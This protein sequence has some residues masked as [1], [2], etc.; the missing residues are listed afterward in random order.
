[1]A[2]WNRVEMPGLFRLTGHP[3][4]TCKAESEDGM[5]G[6]RKGCRS[7]TVWWDGVKEGWRETSQRNQDLS[8]CCQSRH[9]TCS[10]H[11]Q[12]NF[13]SVCT[14]AIRAYAD[15]ACVHWFSYCQKIFWPSLLISLKVFQLSLADQGARGHREQLM[16]LGLTVPFELW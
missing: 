11:F 9:P 5:K 7:C 2:E 12:P 13:S 15:I 16:Y 10:T 8:E 1:M 14:L 6:W 3:W 4:H